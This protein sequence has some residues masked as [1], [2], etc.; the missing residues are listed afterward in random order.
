VIA[1][2]A[3][4]EVGL[5]LLLGTIG[6]LLGGGRDGGGSGVAGN[7]LGVVAGAAWSLASFF[8]IPL[9]ALEGLRPRAALRRSVD[10]VGE[11]W[12]E[13]I[14]GRTGIGTVVFLV[15]VV[16]LA[17]LFVGADQ[18]RH[19]S[20]GAQTAGSLTAAFALLATIAFSSLLGVIF[21]VELYRY[22]TEGTL[23]GNFQQADVDA[24]FRR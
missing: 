19:V 2:W 22:A 13:A 15:A 6:A 23:T 14:S 21:R 16:P 1:R 3:L 24:A 8:V 17:A 9:L 7:L 18:L 20:S 12:G 5:G 11:H 10:L 4:L